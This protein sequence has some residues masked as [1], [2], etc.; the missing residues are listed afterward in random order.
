MT[1]PSD[2][3]R[4]RAFG[5]FSAFIFFWMLLLNALTPYLADDFTFAY[6]FDTGLRLQNLPQLLQSLAYHYYEWSGRVVVKFFAQGFTMFPKAVF[7]V[8]NAAAYLGLGLVIYRLA[9]GRRSGRYDI[10]CF[11]AIQIAL[12]EISPAF[13]QTNLWMCG[14]CNY[15]WASLGCLS[16]LLPWRYYLQKP[17]S[18]TPR[19][20]VG[21]ALAGL[22]TGWLS[23]NTSAGMLV[24]LVL[25]LGALV[26][27]RQKIPAWMWT[28]LGG[29]VAGFVIL[30]TARGNYNR[31]SGYG[32]Y[33]Y[34]LTRY[35]VR[36]FN[37]LNQLK[38]HALP[39]L[40]SFAVFFTLL[41]LQNTAK[42]GK[43]CSGRPD[44]AWPIILLAGAMGSNFAMILS[45]DYYE[46]STQGPFTLLTAA[47][48][49]CL[50]QL[51]GDTLRRGL[52]CAAA[53]AGVV[54]GFH[55]LEAGY[56]IAS[57]YVMYNTRDA[58]LRQ[59][60]EDTGDG[61]PQAVLT[62]YA[63]EPY[64][65]WCA[66]YG[67]PDIRENTEDSIGLCRA[68]WYGVGGIVAD[69][70]R[71]YPFPGHTNE[72]YAAGEKAALDTDAGTEGGQGM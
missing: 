4:K 28:G 27:R 33:A 50:V 1:T 36:F 21:M 44:L 67:L 10:L 55:A 24:C 66:A 25:C 19:L 47:C 60:A 7:N 54:C 49:A 18:S 22:L 52:A 2:R 61:A 35:A 59:Q 11:A 51:H 23:E 41:L 48:A 69:E 14:A 62:S 12:W 37:C 30:I 38:D 39:L 5:L 56:D 31:A 29:A 70:T 20:A 42:K 45:P 57:Y 40:F 9:C 68:R 34:A 32:D 71:T 65:H 64:T 8:C 26:A 43:N 58:L 13:G 3:W 6:A 63:I 17:F 16:F 15:L 72:A 53:C 46:R